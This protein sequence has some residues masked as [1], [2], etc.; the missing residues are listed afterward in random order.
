VIE[1][2]IYGIGIGSLFGF[3]VSWRIYI[4]MCLRISRNQKTE[5]FAE[6]LERRRD[7]YD[8]E[9]DIDPPPSTGEVGEVSSLFSTRPGRMF[10]EHIAERNARKVDTQGISTT[11]GEVNGSTDQDNTDQERQQ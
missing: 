7:A 10:L 5:E 1:G 6:E 9:R 2:L 4:R 11:L 3:Y 8:F